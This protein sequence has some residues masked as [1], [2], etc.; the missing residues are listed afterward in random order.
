VSV[1]ASVTAAYAAARAVA[2]PEDRIVVFGSFHTV[3]DILRA[4][5]AHDG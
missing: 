3:G 4:L 2:G 5:S 1:H